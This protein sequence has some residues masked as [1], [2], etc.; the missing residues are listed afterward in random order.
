MEKYIKRFVSVLNGVVT[1][2][3]TKHT[4]Q[5]EIANQKVLKRAKSLAVWSQRKR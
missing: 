2:W 3:L 4:N 1:Q 5:G